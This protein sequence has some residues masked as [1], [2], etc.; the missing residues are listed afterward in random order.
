MKTLIYFIVPAL[1]LF[2]GFAVG[3]SG[4]GCS[5]TTQKAAKTEDTA[6]DLPEDVTAVSAPDAATPTEG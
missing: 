4:C 2:A 5:D 3:F 1:L 6:I